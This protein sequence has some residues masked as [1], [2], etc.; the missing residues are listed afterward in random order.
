MAHRGEGVSDAFQQ[1]VT[2]IYI[3]SQDRIGPGS[4]YSFTSILKDSFITSHPKHSFEVGFECVSFM[5]SNYPINAYYNSLQLFED[6]GSEYL[7][8]IT[9]GNYSALELATALELAIG[10]ESTINTYT[11]SYDTI[12]ERMT[13]TSTGLFQLESCSNSLYHIIGFSDSA[14]PTDLSLTQV[15]EGLV[16]LSGSKY[17]DI[18]TNL[19]TR[20]ISTKALHIAE[21]IP[22]DVSFGEYFTYS[23]NEMGYRKID[24]R[25]LSHLE[26]QLIDDRGNPYLLAET[27]PTH[28]KLRLLKSHS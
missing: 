17:I 13:I 23:P 5:N 22:L 2:D 16:D 1:D 9:E 26:V 10:L 7:I 28:L 18:T 20:N 3:S 24:I 27:T 6:G 11:V 12:T 19:P 8:T 21:R 4:S 25:N 14:L 15:G